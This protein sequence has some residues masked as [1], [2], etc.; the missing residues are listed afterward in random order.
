MV[1]RRGFDA[2][3]LRSFLGRRKMGTLPE[4]KGALGTS[5]PMTVFRKLKELGYR[6]S[7]SHR[8]KHYTLL[9]IPEYD[10]QGLWSCRDVWFSWVGYLP[11][12]AKAF[13]EESEGGW[14]AQELESQVHVEAKQALL[15]LV[16]EGQIGR[17]KLCGVYVYFSG[18]KNKRRRQ[19]Y[20]RAAWT[21]ATGL[22]IVSEG[23]VSVPEMKAAIV[24]FFSLLDEKQRR[25]YAGL[26][27]MRQGRGGD[28]GIAGLLGL[29]AHTVARGRREL[30]GGDVEPDRVRAR[31]G[32]RK[33]VEKKRPRS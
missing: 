18:D 6:S 21:S 22:G 5:A 9:D 17:E 11:E 14:T 30:F 10:E 26:E 20:H 23:I 24:L 28:Q 29:D 12:T 31:G 25:L 16:R 32:G 19:R 15:K 8:G 3:A 4:L 33:A 7:Y 2:A 27:S 1:S 13:V